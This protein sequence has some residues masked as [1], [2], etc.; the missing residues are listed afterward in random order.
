MGEYVSRE[1]AAGGLYESKP[2]SAGKSTTAAA[3][4]LDTSRD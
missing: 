1:A 4:C 3:I 2:A